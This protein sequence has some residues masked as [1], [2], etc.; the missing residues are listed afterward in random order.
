MSFESLMIWFDSHNIVVKKTGSGVNL[1]EF[2]LQLYNS[3][4]VLLEEGTWSP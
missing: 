2:P 4:A 3:F 1:Q